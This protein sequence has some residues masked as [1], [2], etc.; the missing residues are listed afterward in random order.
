MNFTTFTMAYAIL[1]QLACSALAAPFSTTD[2]SVV[3]RASGT[4]NKLELHTSETAA[5]LN[6]TTG[7]HTL[8]PLIARDIN[9]LELCDDQWSGNCV[10]YTFTYGSCLSLQDGIVAKPGNGVSSMI[11]FGGY[12]CW[13][14]SELACRGQLVLVSSE[15]L[16]ALEPPADNN[17]YSFNCFPGAIPDKRS[18]SS[19]ASTA[20]TK[21]DDSNMIEL[22]NDDNV[23][24]V[25]TFN[26][27]QIFN[28][29][30]GIIVK[31]TNGVSSISLWP[32]EF[33][34]FYSDVNCSGDLVFAASDPTQI[35]ELAPPAWN[36]IW[37]FICYHHPSKATSTGDASLTIEQRDAV[38]P[39]D[40]SNPVTLCDDHD[41]G[42]CKAYSFTYG[43]CVSLDDG[44]VAKPNN[45]VSSVQ[46]NGDGDCFFWSGLSCTGEVVLLTNVSIS[47]LESPADNNI[48]S[49]TC[50]QQPVARRERNTIDSSPGL[51]KRADYSALVLYENPI[52]EDGAS[53]WYV[54]TM[55]QCLDLSDG[56]IAKPGNGVSGIVMPGCIWCNFFD[57]HNCQGDIVLVTDE[58]QLA[59]VPPADDNIY[60][61]LCQRG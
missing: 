12:T 61:L 57:E 37:S 11:L 54:V 42:N 19:D 2:R 3:E 49:F 7:S 31:P 23:C 25:Y 6:I 38:N 35:F 27:A 56:F 50:Y 33:C 55:N 24:V 13:F 20:L 48:Y 52:W 26:Y 58:T 44:V 17:I 60:S 10:Q 18:I 59:L 46:L 39:N 51:A 53:Q 34:S 1:T 8:F 21:R 22:C 16:Y 40:G 5:G 45:G 36:N 4:P 47:A 32:D 29:E 14:Y 43:K 28:L 15:S 30:D 41:S 9:E